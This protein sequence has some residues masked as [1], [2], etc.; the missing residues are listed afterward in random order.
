MW[1]LNQVEDIHSLNRYSIS[2]PSLALRRIG[3]KTTDNCNC[4]GQKRQSC[5]YCS[6]LSQS[7][8]RRTTARYARHKDQKK[9]YVCQR[10]FVFCLACSSPV[11]PGW[12]TISHQQMIGRVGEGMT[13]WTCGQLRLLPVNVQSI[14][15]GSFRHLLLFHHVTQPGHQQSSPC[16]IFVIFFTLTHFQAWKFYTQKRV[17]LRQKLSCDKTA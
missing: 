17:N 15:P 13:A 11:Y 14:S 12:Q 3:V 16:L 4:V 9:S 5:V 8:T 7:D 1:C 10:F 6:Y 2:S